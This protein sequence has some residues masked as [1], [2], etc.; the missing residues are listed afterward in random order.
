MTGPHDIETRLWPSWY[1]PPVAIGV[2]EAAMRR[3]GV[4]F[5]VTCEELRGGNRAKRF[6][7]PRF[8]V[9]SALLSAG[10]STPR[11]GVL[12]GGRDH[13]TVMHGIKR[14]KVLRDTDPDFARL[15]QQVAA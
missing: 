4:A 13:T 10:W 11:I 7:Y 14:A 1:R 3:A 6:A 9:M 2:G 8:A 15:L 5:G 12:L